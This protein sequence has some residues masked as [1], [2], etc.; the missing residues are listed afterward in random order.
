MT[1]YNIMYDYEPPNSINSNAES[2]M[3]ENQHMRFTDSLKRLPYNI[4]SILFLKLYEKFI[5]LN[6]LRLKTS[7]LVRLD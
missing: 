5:H 1:I 7:T 3:F 6:D 4:L 2:A